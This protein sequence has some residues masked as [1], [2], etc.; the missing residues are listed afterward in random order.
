MAGEGH[1]TKCASLLRWLIKNLSKA[2]KQ[3]CLWFTHRAHLTRSFV[4][5]FRIFPSMMISV[6]AAPVQQTWA[7]WEQNP[8]RLAS[9]RPCCSLPTRYVHGIGNGAAFPDPTCCPQTVRGE[10]FQADFADQS[11]GLWFHIWFESLAIWPS[12]FLDMEAKFCPWAPV[13][14]PGDSWA[15]LGCTWAGFPR[16]GGAGWALH[17]S[18][19]C[20]L[21]VRRGPWLRITA[22]GRVQFW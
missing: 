4:Y 8:K 6:L 15:F 10:R 13:S 14:C 19:R 12:V 17:S 18:P 2:C 3:T 1:P 9:L 22:G 16:T 5:F 7:A 21:W 20:S 11:S